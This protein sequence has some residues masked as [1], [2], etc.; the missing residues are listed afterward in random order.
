MNSIEKYVVCF[1]NV[2]QTTHFKLDETKTC[3]VFHESILLI[4]RLHAPSA[5]DVDFSNMVKQLAHKEKVLLSL[6]ELKYTSN[7]YV[8]E[9]RKS[10]SKKEE[11]PV[12]IADKPN[13]PSHK[14]AIESSKIF[15]THFPFHCIFF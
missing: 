9:Y 5:K 3:G 6:G 7:T 11:K 4:L 1:K 13:S 2:W 8:K 14:K 12:H 10:Y 15:L